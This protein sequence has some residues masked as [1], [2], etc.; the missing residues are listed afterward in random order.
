M[1]FALWRL[2]GQGR[3][4]PVTLIRRPPARHLTLLN[5]GT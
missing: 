2:Q 3:I 4:G 1:T 5:R